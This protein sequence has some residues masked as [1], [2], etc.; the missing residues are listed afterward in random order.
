VDRSFR[1]KFRQ[2]LL[3]LVLRKAPLGNG[4]HLN[5][6][7]NES[8]SLYI[9]IQQAISNGKQAKFQAAELPNWWKMGLPCGRVSQTDYGNRNPANDSGYCIYHLLYYTLK[10]NIYIYIYLNYTQVLQSVPRSKHSS[11]RL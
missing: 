6:T 9:M 5:V 7:I 4:K 3:I 11:S 2:F 8:S 1:A 10:I